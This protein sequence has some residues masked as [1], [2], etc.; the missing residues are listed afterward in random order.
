MPAGSVL[1]GFFDTGGKMFQMTLAKGDV[2]IFPRGLV[3]FII[4]YGFSLVTTFSPQVLNSQNPGVV[5]TTHAI[6]APDS[7]VVDR[8]MA[9]MMKFREMEMIDNYTTNLQRPC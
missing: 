9:R 5:G 6:F 4:N 8:L 3:H 1:A 7:D 2:L